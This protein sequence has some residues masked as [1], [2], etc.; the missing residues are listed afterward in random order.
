M[1]NN[2]DHKVLSQIQ[3][4]S[5]TSTELE[6]LNDIL[7]EVKEDGKSDLLDELWSEDYEE[8]P[9]DIKTFITDPD[10]LGSAF[11]AK[12]G[13]CLIYDYW[14]EVLS[15]VFDN[16]SKI[17]ELALSGAIGLGKSTIA[18]IGLAYILHRL[19]CLKDPAA[20]YRLTKGSRIAIALFNITLDQGYGVGYAKLQNMLKQSPW[21]LRH[22]QIVGNKYPTYVPDKDIDI[23]VG[24]KSEHF[25][26]RDVFAAFM[27]ELNFAN[28]SDAALEK[29]S[30]M[31]LYNTI[32]RRMESRYM[33]SGKIP[34]MLFLVS[35]KKSTSDFLEAYISKNKDKPH[36]RVVDEPIWVVK[37]SVNNY[38]GDTFKVAVGNTYVKSKILGED[39]DYK[40]YQAN[41]QEV[42]DVPVEHREAFEQDINS[43]LMD[44]AGKSLVSNLKYIYYDK[45]KLCYR[46]YLH[47]PF[48][49][50]EITLGFDDD[51]EIRDFFIPEKLSRLDI[52]KPHFIHWDASKSGDATGLAMSTIVGLSEVRRLINGEMYD[53]EDIVHKLEFALRILAQPGSEIPFYKIRNFIYYLKF[54]LGYNVL[55]VTC[56]S[57]QSVDTI[58]QMN[59]N[60]LTA[61]T[62]SVDRTMAPYTTLKNAINEG[63]II[64]PKIP[65]LEFELLD[66][67]ED[68]A[69][70]KVDHTVEGRKDVADAV[71][72]SVFGA[73]SEK[74]LLAGQKATEDAKV[75]AAV[76]A[77][78]GM[79]AGGAD[80]LLGGKRVLD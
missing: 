53:K 73:L 16:N 56:D 58:Q 32:K 55:L 39:E 76:N 63:R 59:L 48:T 8:I 1:K 20:Y 22:G 36:I 29:S 66:V 13:T 7:E 45:L 47:N 50:D 46:D 3:G 27:D 15:Q 6:L 80:W 43:A 10:Y 26:G 31:K 18:D 72:G 79:D 54:E 69:R 42:I 41:G 24:S 17:I 9:V 57:F 61:K 28:G 62:Q 78:R 5:L 2:L 4:L 68:K 65:T 19:L 14:L 75:T 37:A 12:D 52:S 60:G 40:S 71:V 51:T 44:I 38:S 11:T 21:F 77:R 49:M 74:E 64:M 23:L 70:G 33:K 25:I 34:G 67:E 30:I 35:S